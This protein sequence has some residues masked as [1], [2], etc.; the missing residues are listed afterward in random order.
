[1]NNLKCTAI[2]VI[3]LCVFVFSAVSQEAQGQV[4]T[5][6]R[7]SVKNHA[8]I[9]PRL[10]KRPPLHVP[11][12]LLAVS[13]EH[14]LK[15]VPPCDISPGKRIGIAPLP[16]PMPRPG[17]NRAGFIVGPIGIEP[18]PSPYPVPDRNRVGIAPLPSPMPRPGYARIGAI[19]LPSP[20]PRS[21]VNRAGFDVGPV[22]NRAAPAE[23]LD[24]IIDP[25]YLDT[26]PVNSP[27][28]LDL[29]IDMH[30]EAV[31]QGD[32]GAADLLEEL[33][34]VWPDY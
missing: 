6:Y 9:P 15:K 18:N 16:S 19:P 11:D 21:G 14:I 25:V 26:G 17:V 28:L 2:A 8:K 13:R 5:M 1:M 23:R 30:A 12:G 7:G 32:L 31:R 4:T 27:A 22:A 34:V 33:I 29:L 3:A 20:M 24:S 10:K